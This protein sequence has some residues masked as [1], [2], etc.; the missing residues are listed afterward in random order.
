M[1]PLGYKEE[2]KKR[3]VARHKRE[4]VRKVLGD[5]RDAG[6]REHSLFRILL[7]SL[8]VS[9]KPLIPSPLE[10]NAWCEEL[11]QEMTNS[12]FKKPRKPTRH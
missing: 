8:L 5:G 3:H 11:F 1:V 12:N 6:F 7:V 4:R 10:R 9:R 2:N